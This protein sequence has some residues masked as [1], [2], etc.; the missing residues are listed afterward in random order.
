[1]DKDEL[2][3]KPAVSAYLGVPVGTLERWRH[4]G[5]GPRGFRIEGGRVRYRRS[6]VERWLSEQEAAELDRRVSA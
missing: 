2:L 5:V 4:H 3:D 6:E 1:M